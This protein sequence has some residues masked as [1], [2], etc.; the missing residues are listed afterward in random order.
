MFSLTTRDMRTMATEYAIIDVGSN[1]VRFA[2]ERC[3]RLP[4]KRVYT[5]RLGS[6]LA[7]SGRLSFDTMEASLFVIGSLAD[8]AR[9]LG[10][11]P[12]AY[13]T[14]AVRDALNGREFADEVYKRCGV[15]V[16]ILSGE[17]EACL[18][19]LGACGGADDKRALIDI[20]GASMQIVTKSTAASW[21]TGCVRCADIVADVT[22]GKEPKP[23]SDA[24][25]T[26]PEEKRL[27]LRRYIDGEVGK[28]QIEHEGAV[29]VGGTITTIAAYLLG[30]KEYREGAVDGSVITLDEVK[31][32]LPKLVLMGAEGRKS[33]PMLQK[34]HDI[35]YYGACILERAMEL[36]R[37]DEL[38]CSTK[39]G[40][41]GYLYKIRSAERAI[42]N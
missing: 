20:G 15:P 7:G 34:R 18:A 37:I 12:R 8:E 4:Q 6:G 33:H 27:A 35:I 16:D 5:T 10:F 42:R 29:G 36:M 2:F 25:D 21:R 24:C 39:D 26:A 40:M 14:S 38:T 11:C 23:G 41:E 1:S 19:F 17:D 9:S 32:L 13:A 3:G 22:D 28:L 31:A 30:L